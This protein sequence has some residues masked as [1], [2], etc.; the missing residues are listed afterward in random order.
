[1]KNVLFLLVFLSAHSFLLAQK[2]KKTNET[3]AD[4]ITLI[5]LLDNCSAADSVSL[6][7]TDGY[8]SE[9]LQFAKPDA[10]GK[11]TF[12][13]PRSN[14]PQFYFVGLNQDPDKLKPVLLGTEKEVILAGGCFNP[15]LLEV[16]SSKVNAAYEDARR[17][18]GDR[19]S[20][21]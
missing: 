8:F 13:V 3:A 21:V 5:C 10:E 4:N 1:M 9:A 20:V 19:K 16:K 11:L 15:T 2:N 7:R 6:W 12:K 18:M 17:K 14:A